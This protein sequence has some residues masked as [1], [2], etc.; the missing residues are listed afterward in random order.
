MELRHIL[1]TTTAD[2]TMPEPHL[3]QIRAA[4][5][6]AT[7]TAKRRTE[8][9]PEDVAAA[10]VIFGWP[11]PQ[12]VAEAPG[13]R[14]VQLGSAGSDGWYGIRPADLLLTKASGTFGIPI[15]EWV[16]ATML[17]LTRNLHLY[18]DQQRQAVWQPQGGA[19]EVHGST[20]GI[21]G[22]GDIGQEVAKRV[23]A[24]GCRVLGTRRSDGPA[25]AFVEAV[26]PLDELIPQVDFLV[27]AMPGTPETRRLISAD[28]L[29]RLKPGSYLINVGRG[30][31]VDE[32]ALIAAL[33]SGRLA[34]AALDVTAVEPLPAESPLWQMAQVIITPHTS[35][36]SAV[37]TDRRL[38]IF[39]ENLRRYQAD[40]PLINLVDRQAGY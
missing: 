29:A 14:W 25:P 16:V 35:P 13:V 37:N 23:S 30:T 15:S 3:A 12:W 17:M 27:L 8:L 36:R 21:V 32:E 5:P 22:L 7:V 34:G 33:R 4:A 10:D 18:R 20:V 9:T 38:A 28:R 11:K 40:E 26:M 6:S 39:C 19:R 2:F 1:V 24:L 31:T